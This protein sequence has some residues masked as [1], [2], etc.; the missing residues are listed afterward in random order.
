MVPGN[1][2][3]RAGD[4]PVSGLSIGNLGIKPSRGTAN[5]EPAVQPA[6]HAGMRHCEGG[7]FRR[8]ESNL[9]RSGGRLAGDPRASPQTVSHLRGG[10]R[11]SIAGGN[12]YSVAGKV[13]WSAPRSWHSFVR[14]AQ[15]IRSITS[16]AKA[17]SLHHL[18]VPGLSTGLRCDHKS[19]TPR[20]AI[21]LLKLTSWASTESSYRDDP[22]PR[23]SAPALLSDNACGA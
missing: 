10:V 7:Q 5:L 17:C 20:P 21:F 11:P 19:R 8:R 13:L 14:T 18:G 12:R 16:S 2:H 22:T 6:T 3:R 4:L 23:R 9:R 1:R 15:Y